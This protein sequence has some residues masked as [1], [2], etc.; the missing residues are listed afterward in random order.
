LANAKNRDAS[1]SV[2]TDAEPGEEKMILRFALRNFPGESP[3]Q[4]PHIPG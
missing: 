4:N 1:R 2:D 3:D